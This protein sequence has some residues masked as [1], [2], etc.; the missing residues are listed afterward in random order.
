M[1]KCSF[2]DD[3]KNIM[4]VQCIMVF[5]KLENMFVFCFFFFRDCHIT[6]KYIYFFNFHVLTRKNTRPYN[7][8]VQLFYKNRI[9]LTISL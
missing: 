8:R 9:F 2:Y 6:L 1:T 4:R 7:L 3:K 5:S